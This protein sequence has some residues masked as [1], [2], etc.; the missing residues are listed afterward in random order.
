MVAAATA[1]IRAHAADPISVGDM[2]DDA[3]Y[4]QFHFT[5]QFSAA[6]GVSPGR[7]LSA[8]RF[9]VAKQLL[10]TE[11]VGVVEVCHTVGFSSPGTF[12]RR[13][14]AEVGVAPATLRRVADRL[15]GPVLP[16]FRRHPAQA[17]APVVADILIPADLRPDLGD[18]PL[19]WVGLFPRRAPA[20]PPLAGVLRHG[21]GQV[22]LPAMTG[23]PWLLVIAVRATA[24]PLDHLVP[25]APVVGAHPAPVHGGQHVQVTLRRAQPHDHPLVI[26]LAALAP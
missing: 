12:T 3:G 19:V 4:S 11:P 10:L 18:A 1:F 2:A 25:R 13:F 24:D 23:A 26:A 16:A 14:T 5:R 17:L 9:Q 21:D 6:T 15:A 7:Y 8:V 22:R 20:G